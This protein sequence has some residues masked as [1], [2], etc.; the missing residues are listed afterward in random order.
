MI[1]QASD[2]NQNERHK[3]LIGAVLPRPI[4]WVSTMDAQ[5]Q[6][7]LAPFSY[8]TI[9]ADVPMTLIFCPQVPNSSG[10]RKDTLR[11]IGAVP[12]FVINLTNEE[13]AE[14]MNR[15]ATSLPPG[16]S[17][18]PW[19]G[20]TPVPSTLV[21]VP[22]VAEAPI[23]FECRLQQLV[24]ISDLPG[25]GTAV[26]GEVQCIHIR[27]DLYSEGRI[28]LERLRPIGRIAGAGYARVTDT[29]EMERILPPNS[30]F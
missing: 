22:R 3:L 6:P 29:F 19:A 13:T 16:E 18:F 25:G 21:S 23:A 1:L 8:F 15:S 5:G 26:F 7:N 24:V 4:A 27:D 20:V 10:S 17:E 11:N 14:A 9:G 12:E 2:L 28:L 30:E